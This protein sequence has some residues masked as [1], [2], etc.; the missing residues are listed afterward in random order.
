[1]C[2]V[3]SNQQ[4]FAIK[5]PRQTII[6]IMHESNVMAYALVNSGIEVPW[7]DRALGL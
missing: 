3:T 1:M 2:W 7:K 6:G 5:E 4:I